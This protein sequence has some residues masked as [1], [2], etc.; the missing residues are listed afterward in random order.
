MVFGIIIGVVIMG[1][2][3]YLALDK[4]STIQI[5]IACIAALAL[6]ILTV[7]ICI[8][9]VVTGDK[10]VPV[11]PSIPL[12]PPMPPEK[13]KESVNVFNILLPIIFLIALFV[14]I[15]VLAMREQKKNASNK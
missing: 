12:P 6:M 7:I 9:V 5:R 10:V 14:G 15:V 2:V 8:V 4:K 13:E 3:S 1:A 11:D